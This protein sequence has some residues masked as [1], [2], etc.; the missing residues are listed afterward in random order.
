MRAMQAP[1]P[2]AGSAVRTVTNDRNVR[3]LLLRRGNCDE[4]DLSREL[5]RDGGDA[6]SK[7]TTM[8][9]VVPTPGCDTSNVMS[10][11]PSAGVMAV[12][13]M[14]VTRRGHFGHG[15]YYPAPAAITAI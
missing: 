2:H 9:K 14:A 1:T 4:R 6:Q 7:G 13:V 12:N 5:R 8:V 15:S 3:M 11:L 10:C